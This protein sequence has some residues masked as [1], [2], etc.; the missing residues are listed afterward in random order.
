MTALRIVP[1]TPELVP[2][3]AALEQATFSEPWSEQ[4][5]LQAAL[6]ERYRYLVC[7]EDDRLVGYAGLLLVSDEGQV[8]NV[9]V[10]PQRRG[11]G[12][13]TRLMEA[14][15]EEAK[16]RGAK[17]LFLE[18]R[19]GNSAARHVYEK[20]G[21]T[22]VGLRRGFYRKPPEDAVVML[23]DMDGQRESLL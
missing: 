7:L 13:A 11:Q 4:S 18:V 2:Q 22:A 6:D 19:A 17:R 20:S 23:F 12:V 10:R 21:F 8:T 14:L 5:L 9:A 3:V 16:K 1:M 15:K